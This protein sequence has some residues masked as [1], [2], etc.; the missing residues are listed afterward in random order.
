MSETDIWNELCFCIF[1][2]NV[3]YDLAK[4][5]LSHLTKN[6][7]INPLW[8]CS[9]RNSLSILKN[10]LSKSIYLPK[11]KDG[12][13]RKYRYPEKRA[14]QIVQNSKFVYREHNGLKQI[15]SCFENPVETREY[16]VQNISGIGIKEAS[17]FLRNIG[18]CDSLA[19]IDVHVLNFLKQNHFV[20]QLDVPYLTESRYERLEIILQNLAEFHGLDLGI[21]DLA[22][23]HYMRSNTL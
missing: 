10:E 20:N 3:N 9:K 12:T 7:F 21:L 1:S 18:Y 4:S 23:W 22:I 15:L 16:L 8:L 13:L 19:I 2:D 5:T 6:N 14:K 17:H 11:K